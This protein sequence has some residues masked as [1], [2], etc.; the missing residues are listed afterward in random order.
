MNAQSLGLQLLGLRQGFLQKRKKNSDE[1]KSRYF[2]LDE[3]NLSY[4]INSQVNAT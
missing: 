4:F 2:V 3:E 1:W